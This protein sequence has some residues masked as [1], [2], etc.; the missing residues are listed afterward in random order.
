MFECHSA[1]RQ[2]PQIRSAARRAEFT[3]RLRFSLIANKQH[4]TP[5][6]TQRGLLVVGDAPT[7]AHVF[8]V[9]NDGQQEYVIAG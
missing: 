5:L 4:I 3:D 7:G 2:F 8:A 1:A 6:T 9:N